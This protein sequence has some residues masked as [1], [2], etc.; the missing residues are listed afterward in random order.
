MGLTLM[1]FS[2]L[3]QPDDLGSFVKSRANQRWLWHATDHKTG[4]IPAHTLGKRSDEVFPE[5]RGLP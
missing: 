1:D 2:V 3:V 4:K 5:L